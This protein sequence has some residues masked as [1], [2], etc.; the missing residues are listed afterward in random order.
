MNIY[1]PKFDSYLSLRLLGRHEVERCTSWDEL[2][3]L[4]LEIFVPPIELR[5][6][7]S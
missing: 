2:L 1:L 4:K 6:K 5:V 7:E 3:T